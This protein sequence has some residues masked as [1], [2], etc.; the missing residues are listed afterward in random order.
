MHTTTLRLPWTRI[1]PAREFSSPK[2]DAP[3]RV[4]GAADRATRA[5]MT[6]WR[7]NRIFWIK[8][9]IPSAL[10]T[11]PGPGAAASREPEHLSSRCWSGDVEVDVRS[12]ITEQAFHAMPFAEQVGLLRTWEPQASSWDG[13]VWEGLAGILQEEVRS[14]PLPFFENASQFIGL[15]PLYSTALIRGFLDGLN[16]KTV[17]SWKPFWAPASWILEQ[18][19]AETEIRDAFSGETQLGRRWQSCR[20]EIARFIVATLNGKLAPLPLA[21]RASVWQLIAALTGD[22]SPAPADEAREDER[23]MDPLAL[24]LN[25]VRGVAVHAVFSFVGWIRSFSPAESQGGQDLDDVR[26]ARGALEALLD[27]RLESALAIRSVFGANLT[28]LAYWAEAWLRDHLEQILP[29]QG[30]DEQRKTAWEAFI[31]FSSHDS[32]SF[33]LLHQQY[34]VAIDRMSRDVVAEPLPR[35]PRVSLGQ[36]L[37]MSCCRGLFDFEQPGNLLAVFLARAP[38]PVRAEVMAYVGRSLAQSNQPIA[39]AQSAR[40]L[41]LW[42]WLVQHETP[43]GG[44]GFQHNAA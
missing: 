31:R 15:N 21:E 42:N 29:A 36:H 19:D 28:Q 41:K 7:V 26:E 43:S 34:S 8:D 18:P 32:K 5:T 35:D 6:R 27:P 23:I 22:P 20:L 24:S 11:R 39:P 16:G 3:A 9:A 30:Q 38:E 13:P 2:L 4:V 12:P 17:A 44:P 1:H 10:G 37:V 33:A 14:Q 40:L 25:T